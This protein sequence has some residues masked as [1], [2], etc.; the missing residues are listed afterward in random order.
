MT[1]WAGVK[2]NGK[3]F[4]YSHL[5][6]VFDFLPLLIL[7]LGQFGTDARVPAL[8]FGK[9][10]VIAVGILADMARIWSMVGVLL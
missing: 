2:R 9:S 5:S 6:S 7:A 1:A 8:L 10:D 4:A 3:S